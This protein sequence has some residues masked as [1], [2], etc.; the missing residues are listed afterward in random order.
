MRG[1]LSWLRLRWVL[2]AWAVACARLSAAIVATH[3]F[4]VINDE[5]GWEAAG[6]M[7]TVAQDGFGGGSLRGD[8]DSQGMFFT[9]T[10]GSFRLEEPGAD[11]LGAYPGTFLITG[12][13]FDLFAA[14]VIPV[15]INLRLFSG[16]SVNF[17]TLN[18]TGRAWNDWEHFIVTLS[19]PLWQGDPSVRNN[20]TAVELQ[21]ARGSA[22]AQSYYLDNF[23]TSSNEIDPGGGGPGGIVPEPSTIMMLLNAG[24][25]L[26]ALHRRSM[27][28]LPITKEAA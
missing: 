4:D 16:L 9:P 11:F 20:V 27:H 13:S 1:N 28:K 17:L 14:S 10:T 21:I 22:A 15:D 12:F 26:V 8:F 19:D 18:I 23:E 24:L 6:D 25:L 3:E 5:Q 2:S 7:V